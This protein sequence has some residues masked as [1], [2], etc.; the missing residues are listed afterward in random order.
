MMKRTLMLSAAALAFA[1]APAM[2]TDFGPYGPAGTGPAAGTTG[3]GVSSW[4][5][6]GTAGTYC[7]LGT[8]TAGD[9]SNTAY[10]H[11]VSISTG[12]SGS[13][14]TGT[15]NITQFQGAND[16]ANAWHAQIVMPNTICNVT[17]VVSAKSTNGGLKY[18]GTQSTTDTHF[19]TAEDYTINVNYGSDG[20]S[21]N[22]GHASGMTTN[23]VLFGAKQP[24][25]GTFQIDLYGSADSSLYLL[26]GNYTDTA[27]I[28][29]A[30]KA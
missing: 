6:N 15:V 23:H 1:A 12:G 5:I 27:T 22:G 8:E 20:F 25:V 13:A 18:A 26:A 7:V 11:N 28:T 9:A 24:S 10:D 14:Q 30:P 16:Q 4:A 19:T 2:A 29:L 21:S 3:G 17:S